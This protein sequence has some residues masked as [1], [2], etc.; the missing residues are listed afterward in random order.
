MAF[1]VFRG[2]P[3][4]T[5]NTIEFAYESELTVERARKFY[6]IDKELPETMAQRKLA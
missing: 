1:F 6:G 3:G 4:G 5:L 2:F